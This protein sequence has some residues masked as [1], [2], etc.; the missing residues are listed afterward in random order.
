MKVLRRRALCIE[1]TKSGPLYLLTLRADE[2]FEVAEVTRIN[3]SRSNELIGY[4][5]AEVR[6]HVEDILEYLNGDVV[7]FPNSLIL[8]LSSNVRFRRS[9]GPDNDDGLAKAGVLEIPIPASDGPKAA[10]IVDGQQRALALSRAERRDLPVPISAFVAETVNRQRDQFLRI[11][12]A[13]PL[14]RGLVAELL[15]EVSIPLPRTLAAKQLPSEICGLLNTET[16]SPFYGLIRRASTQRRSGAVITD[17][18]II[19]MLR[20]SMGSPAGCLFPYRNLATGETDFESIWRLVIVYWNGVR[21]AFPEA[22]GQ[23]PEQSRL[24]HGVG[25]RAMG[26]LMDKVMGAVRPVDPGA[27]AHV[28]S[29][30]ATI[31]PH[32][33][34]TSG[35]WD[36]LSLQWNDVENTSRNQRLLANVLIRLYFGA[37]QG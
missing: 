16:D 18:S 24:M 25:I 22:W 4:Q 8:A 31:A 26:R 17:T 13:K 32:C 34:W 33:H 5:R 30:M 10:W 11:N 19:E 20:E 12:N 9:R 36:E 3:R 35:A 14:P 6:Q 29:A 7:L 28:R 2:I 1:Q 37:E 21:D 23:P 27:I 15:P